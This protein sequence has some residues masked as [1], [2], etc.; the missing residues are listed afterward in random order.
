M[1]EGTGIK[2]YTLLLEKALAALGAKTSVLF[3]RPL[4]ETKDQL[5]R[6]VLFYDNHVSKKSR[7]GHYM[8]LGRSWIDAGLNR[9][10]E[11][12]DIPKDGVVILP[13]L[14]RLKSD[15]LNGDRLFELAFRRSVSFGR[16]LD[17]K[18]PKAVDVFH[19]TYPIPVRV[20]AAKKVVTIHDVIPLKL[21]YATLDNKV[22]TLRRHRIAVEEA[23]LIF[24]VSE[25]SKR[26]IIHL[27]DADPEKVVVTH[28]P[29]RFKPLEAWETDDKAKALARLELPPKGYMLF[30]GAIEPKKN[31]GRLLRAYVEA[32]VDIP[33][34]VA[35]P[36]AW[37]WTEE[38]GWFLKVEDPRITRKVKFLDHISADDLRFVY[39][40]ANGLM[41]PSL[42]EGYGLPLVEAMTFGLP[43]MTSQV[44]SMP[45]VCGD[46]ALYVDPFD[47]RDMR[48]KIEQLAGDNAARTVLSHAGL[49]RSSYLT[50]EN[51]A[52]Q[53][54]GGYNRLGIGFKPR[55]G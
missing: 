55:L 15:V 28:Q 9:G 50:A 44:S 46:A 53:I 5:L 48:L 31:L 38:I 25:H 11:I 49:A 33:L 1:R 43:I 30:V 35:G 36:R 40:G 26:D 3:G 45:E 12:F 16:Y 42:Y 41:F 39:A 2:T 34:V 10:P 8:L 37:M 14:S 27:L 23:D 24:T 21:P 6:E 18:L 19:P 20:K 32:D 17:I 22:E 47:V 7:L 51:F 54:A 29:S 52:Q 13:E 4:A